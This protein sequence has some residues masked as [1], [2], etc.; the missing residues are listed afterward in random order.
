MLKIFK[1]IWDF[2]LRE[3]ANIKASIFFGFL[4]ALFNA[5]QFGAIYLVLTR[6]LEGGLT[7]RVAWMALGI[8]L[9]SAIGK[10]LTQNRSQLMQTHAGYFM[11]AHKRVDIGVKL[12]RVPMGFF[13][14]FSLGHLTSL[15]TTNLSLIEMWVPM[16]L[17]LVLGNLLNSS[18]FIIWLTIFNWRVGAI[19]IG[20][21]VAF[22]LVTS[23]MEKKSQAKASGLSRVTARLTKEVL[24]SLQG[25][26]VIKSYKL[27]G[28]NNK[29]LDEAIEEA[30]EVSL[31]ME[32]TIIP[33]VCLQG[34]VIRLTTALMVLMS[35]RLYLEG[36]IPLAETIVMMIAAF[37]ILTPLV[38]AGRNMALLRMTENA[39]DELN[40]VDS[41]P[42]MEEGDLTGPVSDSSIEIRDVSFSYGKRT[43]L[44]N[45][46]AK[47]PAKSLTA[48]VG[49]SGSGKTTL[50]K[51]LARF[52][53]V[54]EGSIS[55]GGTDI[56]DY[57]LDELM[58]HISFVFQ[59]VYLFNDTVENN[60]K[61]GTPEASRE[62]V[63]E[64]AKKAMCH[65]F[66]EGL[67]DGYD[68][69]I[70]EGGASLSG[71]EKQRISIARS[72]LKDAGIVIFDEATANVDPEN[73]NK[74]QAAI[75][76]L[77]EDKTVIMIAHKLDTIRNADLILVLDQGKIV[78]R[79]T[80]EDLMDQG[81]LYKD[82]IAAKG[83]ALS[84]KL[85]N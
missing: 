8:M 41:M 59:D 25:M 71:G 79:G 60:I 77:T 13:S 54:N 68:T 84:W 69:I 80:H 4:N 65:D 47:L 58:S 26:E 21:L 49:P 28:A 82:L 14:D 10:V 62:E 74:L 53:D 37:V 73:E 52:W 61:F 12:K 70:G 76:S 36:L 38:A 2:S 78:Q 31:D 34:L 3:Q 20:G 11:A 48:L 43:I 42:D 29:N 5:F 39:I 16:I 40:Y 75:E 44:D 85:A 15:A 63:I 35:A 1:K 45:V 50:C 55:L 24:S 56:R 72:L 51:L 57:K 7:G 27:A 64:A 67:E 81:G 46:S 32:K 66:I 18:V 9:V 19:A 22:F 23:A 83:R 30:R 17:V 6:A 33:F